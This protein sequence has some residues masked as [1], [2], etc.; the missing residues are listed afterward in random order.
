MPLSHLSTSI[1]LVHTKAPE[2]SE[3]ESLREEIVLDSS[4]CKRHNLYHQV[5]DP[6][7]GQSTQNGP[8]PLGSNEYNTY[9]LCLDFPEFAV[10]IV[11]AH[12]V[13]GHIG[14]HPLRCFCTA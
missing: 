5:Q 1:K 8:Q 11:A 9:K 12:R 7:Q 4:C 2:S 3:T 6:V 14:V 10:L 13:I